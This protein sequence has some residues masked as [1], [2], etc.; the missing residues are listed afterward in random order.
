MTTFPGIFD[1]PMIVLITILNDGTI[2]AYDYV[3]AGKV[4]EKYIVCGI[5]RRSR[6]CFINSVS[7]TLAMR[8]PSS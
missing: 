3:E 4:P 5:A 7:S 2:I 6:L 8:N 1:L